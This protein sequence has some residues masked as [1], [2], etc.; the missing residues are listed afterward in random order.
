[1]GM[2]I[3]AISLNMK[4]SIYKHVYYSTW[5]INRKG[6]AVL[7]WMTLIQLRGTHWSKHFKTEREAA[8]AVDK[9][10]IEIGKEPVNILKH[11]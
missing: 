7:P 4:S 9:K 1:M 3:L 11:K 8:L 6:D 5:F 2:V 10:L